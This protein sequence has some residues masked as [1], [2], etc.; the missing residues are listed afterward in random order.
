MDLRKENHEPGQDVCG[1]GLVFAG[2][3]CLEFLSKRPSGANFLVLFWEKRTKE[4]SSKT[5]FRVT[6]DLF[7]TTVF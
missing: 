6:E 7:R 4:S 5:K 2:F 1:R 3:F